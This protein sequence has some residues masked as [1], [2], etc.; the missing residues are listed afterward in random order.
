MIDFHNKQDKARLID[1]DDQMIALWTVNDDR[2][3]VTFLPSR[4]MIAA[5]RDVVD[6]GSRLRRIGGLPSDV[7]SEVLSADMAYRVIIDLDW[8]DPDQIKA[9]RDAY[10]TAAHGSALSDAIAV[11]IAADDHA[12][13][14]GLIR[15]IDP[16]ASVLDRSLLLQGNGALPTPLVQAA[17]SANPRVRYEAALAISRLA[18]GAPFAGSSQVKQSLGEMR[19]LGDQ[20][21]GHPCRDA[22]R[23]DH[24]A[25]ANAWEISAIRLTWSA[26]SRSCS[27]VW[28]V[29]ATSG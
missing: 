8:G 20:P 22:C 25:R 23:R 14:I 11:A 16:D 24:S 18:G 28:L 12:A 4:R 19:S 26:V 1:N 7:D 29:A 2:S 15:L 5:Y 27:D 13:A 9:I 21:I 3:G 17:S 6:A 10:G